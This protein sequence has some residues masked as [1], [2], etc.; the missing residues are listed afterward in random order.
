MTNDETEPTEAGI[1]D[2]Q[3]HIF[4][5]RADIARADAK[6]GLLAAAVVPIGGVLLAAP[7]LTDQRGL[8]SVLTW[9]AAVCVLVGVA[10]LGMV[11]WPRLDGDSG[12]IPLADL[13]VAQV[14]D[15][16]RVRSEGLRERE[17]AAVREFKFI[18]KVA[19]GKFSRLRLA[20]L[21][22]GLAGLLALAAGS[23]L[24]FSG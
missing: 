14:V 11:V 23:V 9:S 6:A 5:A 20:I 3:R 12:Y 15:M 2:L 10:F 21:C 7:A 24:A 16:T 17:D 8:A 22:F 4:N 19:I 1:A 13:S 18:S